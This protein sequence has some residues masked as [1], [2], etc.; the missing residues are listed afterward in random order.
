MVSPITPTKRSRKVQPQML[1]HSPADQPDWVA[2]EQPD[3]DLEDIVDHSDSGSEAD[4]NHE[5]Q[6]D[7]ED[8]CK[9]LEVSNEHEEWTMLR[10]RIADSA[11]LNSFS[12]KHSSRCD[13]SPLHLGYTRALSSRRES[14]QFNFLLSGR[15]LLQ[16]CFLPR[17]LRWS[18][19]RYPFRRLRP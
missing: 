4:H 12:F 10:V 19:A 18:S 3:H 11:W 16:F 7:S 17:D 5:R 1:Y 8:G 6:P 9:H 13:P 2:Y 14:S 15:G